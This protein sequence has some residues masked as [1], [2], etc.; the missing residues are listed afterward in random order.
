MWDLVDSEQGELAESV[1]K[2]SCWKEMIDGGALTKRLGGLNN[3]QELLRT[4][5]GL[6]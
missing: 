3:A 5:I 6:T 1:L 4:M 2:E